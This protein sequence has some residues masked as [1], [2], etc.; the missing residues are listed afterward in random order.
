MGTKKQPGK[1]LKHYKGLTIFDKR[2]Y[3]A[4]GVVKTT[5]ISVIGKKDKTLKDKFKNV[6]S[7]IAYIN[8]IA[9][10]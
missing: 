3:D 8:S 9:V 7:A 1:L 4:K 5:N 10:N 2:T 6:E